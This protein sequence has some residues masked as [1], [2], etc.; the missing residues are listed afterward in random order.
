M[1]QEGDRYQSTQL[2]DGG[3][4]I[5]G[6]KDGVPMALAVVSN[7]DDSISIGYIPLAKFYNGSGPDDAQE[8]VRLSVGAATVLRA[9]LDQAIE[10]SYQYQTIKR[11]AMDTFTTQLNGEN[12]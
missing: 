12:N 3:I 9:I 8:Y 7:E 4:L 1:R 6:R 5:H 11:E 10:G 2:G